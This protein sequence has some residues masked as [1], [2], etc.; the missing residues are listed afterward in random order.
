MQG[1]G[2]NTKEERVQILSQLE[3]IYIYGRILNQGQNQLSQ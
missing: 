2:M 1:V 3:E